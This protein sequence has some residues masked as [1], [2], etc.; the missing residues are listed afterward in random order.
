MSER[1]RPS[2]RR[3]EL[4]SSM[5]PPRV[6][7]VDDERLLR[8]TTARLLNGA[9][10]QTLTAANGKEAVALLAEQSFDAIVSDIKMPEMDG[11][12]LLRAVRERDADVP[13]VLMTASPDLAS[14]VEAVTF[15]ALQYLLKP[16]EV[17]E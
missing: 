15:G 13:V 8:E 1:D 5:Q 6:L 9:G 11:I 10:Y 16:F 17:A 4:S 2:S 14:A 7:L 3:I 12:Q